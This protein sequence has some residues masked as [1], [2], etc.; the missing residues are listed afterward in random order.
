MLNVQRI[1][2]TRCDVS[3]TNGYN[4]HRSVCN[5]EQ[6]LQGSHNSVTISFTAASAKT[7]AGLSDFLSRLMKRNLE[8]L[9]AACESLPVLAIRPLRRVQ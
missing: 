3:Q 5:C 6:A 2:S 9:Y 7:H 1:Q 4:L 8:T